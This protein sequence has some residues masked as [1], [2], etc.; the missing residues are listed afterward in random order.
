MAST[1]KVRKKSKKHK[2]FD[3]DY[4]E[5]ELVFAMPMDFE[6]EDVIAVAFSLVK[7][8]FL[9]NICEDEGDECT[10]ED[11]VHLDEDENDI[12]GSVLIHDHIKELNVMEPR[13]GEKYQSFHHLKTCLVNYVVTH[14]YPLRFEKLESTR[15]LAKYGRDTDKKTWPFR[16]YASWMNKERTV[17]VKSMNK[18]HLCARTFTFGHLVSH[19]WIAYH[20]VKEL[21]LKPTMK[22]REIQEFI[23]RQIRITL[24]ISKCH[25]A[26]EKAMIT[27]EGKTIDHYSRIWDYAAEVQR[28]KPGSTV[29]VGVTMNPDGKHYFH[30]FYVCFHALKT[31]WI[32][33][34]R[35]VIGLDGCFLKG[36]IKGEL[37]TAIGRD[38]NNQV[39]P[40][41]WAVVDIEDKE[42]WKWFLE[43]LID[44]VGLQEAVKEL[45]PHAEH[46]QCARHIYANFKKFAYNGEEYK[47][48]FWAATSC[49]VEPG[50]MEVMDRLKTIDV[51]AYEYLMARNP[52][53]W[54]RAYFNQDRVC[55]AFE[56]G[57][58]ES[59]NA[60]IMDAR[61]SPLLTMLEMI[62]LSVMERVSTMHK[63]QETWDGPICRAI[64]KKLDKF[65]KDYRLWSIYS[66]GGGVFETRS[67]HACY[68]VDLGGWY[69]TCR[70]WEL[71]GVPCVH[72][73]AAM[74][75]DQQNPEDFINPVFSIEKFKSSYDT[76]LQ[77]MNGINLWHT[78][79]Y[80]KPLPP[81]SRRMPGRPTV[82]RKRHASENDNRR[83]GKRTVR[84]KNCQQFGHNKKSCKNPSKEPDPKPKK[85]IGTPTVEKIARTSKR[86]RKTKGTTNRNK[87]Q[88]KQ[89]LN[90]YDEHILSLKEAGYND[91]EIEC[92]MSTMGDVEEDFDELQEESLY[93]APNVDI[94]QE[95][96][97]DV[98]INV[99]E[100]LP[101]EEEIVEETMEQPTFVPETCL[102]ALRMLF[103]SRDCSIRPKSVQ[104]TAKTAKS[105]QK[106]QNLCTK[107]QKQ[108]NLCKR[109]Q[110][111]QNLC[112]RQQKQQNLCKKQQKQQNMCKN[113][114]ICVKNSKT[115]PKY[116]VKQDQKIAKLS[117]NIL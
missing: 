112:K 42:N 98:P 28:S 48:I 14:G 33:G 69:C 106:Q 85:K 113:S 43:L 36:Q 35:P 41:C 11:L 70:L 100:S 102:P 78:T 20:L 18:K 87:D 76:F 39:Y 32:H 6:E 30:R 92:L 95:T 101:E 90:S 108:Q 50:L 34:C 84:C 64:I 110:K 2:K 55:E 60:M 3:A 77:P 45:L 103:G 61:K 56:N 97:F 62:R 91:Q 75:F 66:S 59:F 99:P 46:R 49:T 104:K 73:I 27:I 63:V 105:V 116:A 10:D 8:P 57:I 86:P 71:S 65:G 117:R 47:Y 111:H 115:V 24:S 80:E 67:A 58:S 83:P 79:P 114:K 7:D 21:I 31:G 26:K 52:S 107:Q 74:Y 81:I 54:C 68:R 25:R 89:H 37:L 53:S 19:S 16:L 96:L 51:E 44:D 88:G 15:L 109:Q 29:Q 40:I 93:D 17:Q 72:A 1:S 22:L 5:D 13:F 12:A 4:E 82:N 94:T 23:K 9:S 38:A